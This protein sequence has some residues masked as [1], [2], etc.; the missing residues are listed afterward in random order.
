MKLGKDHI[1]GLSPLYRKRVSNY[2]LLCSSLHGGY[3]LM[4]PMDDLE[5]I[6]QSDERLDQ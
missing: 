3:A 2:S 1:I 5:A 6:L 4:V